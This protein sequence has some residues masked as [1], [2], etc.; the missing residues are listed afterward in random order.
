MKDRIIVLPH[1]LNGFME[2]DRVIRVNE[3]LTVSD[4]DT[5]EP[6]VVD[7]DGYLSQHPDHSGWSLMNGYSG[8]Y[9]YAGPVMHASEFIG[10]RMAVDILSTPG[11]Y[12]ALVAHGCDDRCNE[13]E[14]NGSGDG[15]VVARR[16]LP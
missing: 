1:N 3:D 12:V 16:D 14:C 6:E 15:W 9:G 10:G 13:K 4:S 2:F 8:Q 11:E 7:E 5:W